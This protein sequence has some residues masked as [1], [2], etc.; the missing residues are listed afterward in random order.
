MKFVVSSSYL[1]SQLHTIGRVIASKNAIPILDCFLFEVKSNKLT[2]T[3]ADTETR[4]TTSI[5]VGEVEGE[6]SFAIT[7]K[8]ILDSLKELPEQPVTFELNDDTLQLAILY[9]NGKYNLTAQNGDEY[10]QARPAPAEITTI[11]MSVENLLTGIS[12]TLFASAEDELRP[13]MNG[14]YFDLTGE[15]I[16]FVASDGHKLVRFNNL[17]V[18][19][20]AEKPFILPKRPAQVLK[21]VLVRETG[22]T[23][24]SFNNNNAYF[25]FGQTTINV[26]L[27]EG[28]YPN[29]NSVIPQNNPFK[30][31]VDRVLLLNALKRVSVFA[32]PTTSLVKL[33]IDNS[34]IHVSTQDRDYATSAEEQITCTYEGEQ[35]T[36]G[37]KGSYLIEILSNIPSSEVILELADPTRPGIILPFENEADEDLLMLLMPMM[38]ND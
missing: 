11:T 32:N 4:M 23:T 5:E 29:Y 18:K 12:R 26:R 7:S 25:N 35:I 1:S 34:N 27:I 28:R 9:Q 33:S 6:G 8:N 20:N 22:D 38:L 13:V 10:P 17:A 3:A 21:S 24:I 31:V 15:S 36:I 14:V 19:G 16:V 37:F 2:I 30:V